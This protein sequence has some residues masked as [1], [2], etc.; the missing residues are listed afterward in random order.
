MLI[1]GCLLLVGVASVRAAFASSALAFAIRS[2]LIA[3]LVGFSSAASALSTSGWFTIT[4]L[5]V[6]GA[7]NYHLRVYG[8]GIS[9]CL[10]GWAYVNQ[11]QSGS[12]TYITNL[13]MAYAMGKQVSLVY[14]PDSS[15]YCQIIEVAL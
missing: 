13:M 2:G 10:G 11:G 7:D 5:Y 4:K 12:K 3:A 9:D 1:R 8:E 14:Q 15:G 6:S